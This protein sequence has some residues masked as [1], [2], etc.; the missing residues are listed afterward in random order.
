VKSSILKFVEEVLNIESNS[1]KKAFMLY[2]GDT[3]HIDVSFSVNNHRLETVTFDLNKDDGLDIALAAL[4][5]ISETPDENFEPLVNITLT[6]K[7]AIE[8]GLIV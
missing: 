1:E 3:D 5:K 4:K 2:F 7:E 6:K 8:K